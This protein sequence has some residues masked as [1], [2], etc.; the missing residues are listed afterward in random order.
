MDFVAV[1]ESRESEFLTGNFLAHGTLTF[2]AYR[3]L[4]RRQDVTSRKEFLAVKICSREVW[5]IL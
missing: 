4:R 2:A 3:L 5:H 1:G